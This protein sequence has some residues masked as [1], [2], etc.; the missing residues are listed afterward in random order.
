MTTRGRKPGSKNTA[1]LELEALIRQGLLSC[2]RCGETKPLDRF[3]RETRT[4][5][6]YTRM[7]KD[8][9]TETH[10]VRQRDRYRSL[11]E[12]VRP[13]EPGTA[14]WNAERV[15]LEAEG[16]KRC[17]GCR[18]ARSLDDFY[19]HAG[20]LT[21]LCKT[22]HKERQRA[23]RVLGAYGLSV[24]EYEAK[25][26]VPCDICGTTD[27]ARVLDH[28]HETG[29]VR[30]TLCDPCNVGLGHFRDDPARLMAAVIYLIAP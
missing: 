24:E 7:C 17:T 20:R 13:G 12:H 21:P 15:E 30:G 5:T 3:G 6:G 18:A 4:P 19:G 29:A 26:A 28:D 14:E 22:C 16:R 10:R 11:N 8:C 1:T 25:L 23:S 27:T 2:S 9:T